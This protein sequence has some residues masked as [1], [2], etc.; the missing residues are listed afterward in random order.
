MVW[1]SMRNKQAERVSDRRRSAIIHHVDGA[2]EI[3][4]DSRHLPLL[5]TSWFGSPTVTLIER[6]AQWFE[7]FIET[8][9]IAGGRFVIL[10]DAT[11][12]ERPSP[13]VRGRL[14]KLECP[15][16]VVIDRVV[17]VAAPA[18][19]GAVTALSWITGKTIRTVNS[20]DDGLRE[21]L[22]RLDRAGVTRPRKFEF[23]P[24]RAS[25]NG[26]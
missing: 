25:M 18:I 14:S 5:I 8:S 26:S 24:A 20:T 23:V 17:V 1:G 16:D 10:D 21:C 11:R 3:T 2:S 19:R 6:H 4:V 9:R 22:E 15:A 13:S 12:A 7:D